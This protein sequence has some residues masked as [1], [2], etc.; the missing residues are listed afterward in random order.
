MEGFLVSLVKVK[1]FSLLTVIL[2]FSCFAFAV[3]GAEADVFYAVSNYNNGSAGVIAKNGSEYSTLKNL[4]SNFAGDA[5][6]FTFRDHNGDQRAMIREYNYGPN[7]GVY[8]YEPSAFGTPL[9]NR[10]DWGSNIHAAVSGPD[11]KY[12]YLATYES[13]K[14]GSR[15]QDTGEV[16]RVDTQNGYTPDR[17]YQYEAFVGDAGF[18]SSPHGEAI[19]IWNGKIY[20]LFGVSYNG[21]NEYEPT[22]IVEFDAE[23]NRLRSVRLRDE[24]GSIGKNAMRMAAFGGKLYVAN[25]GGYQG[26]RSWGDIWEVDMESMTARRAL[27][28]HDVPYI[29][30]GQAVNVGMYGV[31]FAP[32]GTAFILTGSY[33]ADYVF[34]ARL[35]ITT[36]SRLSEGDVGT[37]VVE[38]TDKRGYSWDILWDEA[39]D[40]LWCMVGTG[41]E[42]RT[43][44][45]GLIRTFTP[46]ELGDNI[47]SVSLL[48]GYEGGGG[49]GEGPGTDG[50]N[51]GGRDSGGGGCDSGAALF[52][53][54]ILCAAMRAGL[55]RRYW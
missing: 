54:L 43:K 21:V 49:S 45:G 47:Y 30:D 27:D 26:P 53:A 8:V 37:A 22:E 4:V 19:E 38:Y 42:A 25:M 29:V 46:S 18:E 33:S 41:L 14:S 20:V 35:F 55:P 7:D 13:Y 52:G 36:A 50:G 51:N 1:F 15:N 6:G 3:G 34:R 40:T 48:D 44:D 9:I 39:A 23:L 32:D 16:I 24:N 2:V 17:R 11:G 10:S 28:G 5:C 31:D 12:L